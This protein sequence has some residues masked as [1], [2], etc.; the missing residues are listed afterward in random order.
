[1]IKR[2]AFLPV[3]AAFSVKTQ[4]N[5]LDILYAALYDKHR[6]DIFI[7]AYGCDAMTQ[8]ERQILQCIESDPMISQQE[9]AD[10]LGITRSSAAVHISNL[11]KKGYIAGK[12]Y[13]LR[14]GSYCVVVGG[15]NMDIGGRAFSRLVDA[16]SNPGTISTSLGGVGRNIAHNLSLMGADVRLLTAFGDDVYGQ[17][18]AAS[19]AELS[20]DIGHALRVPD[21]TTSTYLYIAAPDGDMAMALSDM[22]IC[23]KITPAYL[24]ANLSLLQNAQVVVA[25]ANIPA[26]SLVFLA[27][28]CRQPLFC[29]PVSTTKAEKLRPILHKIH[30]LKPNKLEAEL[31]SGVKITDQESA[32]KA[33]KVLLDKG[34][35]RLFV[36]MGAEG[37]LAATAQEQLWLSNL[38]GNMVNTTGCGDSFMAALVW[39]YLEGTDLRD[40]ALAGLAAASIAME[41]QETI[42]PAMSATEI[43]RRMARAKKK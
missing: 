12:G 9:L 31:L 1:M 16:D 29:D 22:E 28:N 8:R 7:F 40:T 42:N 36:S 3:F 34:V 30:T 5:F 38:P 15:V 37:V 26:E 24:G 19:C 23:K 27:E 2:R 35:H 21:G 20:I 32:V 14:S 4:Q 11:I 6:L 18:I 10:R 39:A 13:V 41:S 43:R 33:A 17:R 25:D